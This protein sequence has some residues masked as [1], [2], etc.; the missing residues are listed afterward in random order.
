LLN[1]G[2]SIGGCDEAQ[3]NNRRVRGRFASVRTEDSGGAS[4]KE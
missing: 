3:S 2:E 4:K 1:G